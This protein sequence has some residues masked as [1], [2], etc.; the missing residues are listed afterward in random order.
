MGQRAR[1]DSPS[2]DVD[3]TTGVQTV[4]YAS[5]AELLQ[6]LSTIDPSLVTYTGNPINPDPSEPAADT[7]VVYCANKSG[8]NCQPPCTVHNGGPGCIYA[9]GTNCLSA[10][11]DV[12]FCSTS[13]CT[14]FCNTYDDCGDRLDDGYCYTPGT[15][16]IFVIPH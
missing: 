1:A 7:T 6:W 8:S 9:P 5:R 15:N 16:S 11:S 10:T 3:D 12:S 13:D 2:V 14:K 4:V